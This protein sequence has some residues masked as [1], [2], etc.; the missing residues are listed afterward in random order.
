MGGGYHMTTCVYSK[1]TKPN[2]TIKDPINL[3]ETKQNQTPIRGELYG[4]PS[5]YDVC[6][7]TTTFGPFHSFSQTD[8]GEIN[9]GGAE[10]LTQ[11]AR[12]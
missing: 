6:F 8:A 5:L 3:K 11:G 1:Q 12:P 4:K 9:Q 10:P 2:Q 7:T